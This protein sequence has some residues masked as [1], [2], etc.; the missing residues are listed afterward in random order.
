[1]NIELWAEQKQ[2]VL[3]LAKAWQTPPEAAAL[4]CLSMGLRSCLNDEVLQKAA[5]QDRER[6]AKFLDSYPTE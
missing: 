3:I 1:M 6:V 4:A 5:E 2:L